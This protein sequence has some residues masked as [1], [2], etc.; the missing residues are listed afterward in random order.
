MEKSRASKSA[1]ANTRSGP[2]SAASD[3][4]AVRAE[5]QHKIDDEATTDGK[6]DSN[7]A[8][9]LWWGASR[10]LNLDDA[11]EPD[12]RVG[13]AYDAFLAQGSMSAGSWARMTRL[14]QIPRCLE[15]VTAYC[16]AWLGFIGVIV[17]NSSW[18]EPRAN[19]ESLQAA[20]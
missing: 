6:G 4:T 7:I 18:A 12:G 20:R 16:P 11:V 8:S 13:S 15:S 9:A 3:H 1:K 5:G 14:S 2:L 19:S 17:E 10:H